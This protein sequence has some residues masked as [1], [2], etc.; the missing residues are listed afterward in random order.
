MNVPYY[1][2]LV[3]PQCMKIISERNISFEQFTIERE[4]PWMPGHTEKINISVYIRNKCVTIVGISHQIGDVDQSFRFKML[5]DGIIGIRTIVM[6]Y[7][8]FSP[9]K[10]YTFRRDTPERVLQPESSYSHF[11]VRGTDVIYSTSTGNLPKSI[12]DL[13]KSLCIASLSY[14]QCVAYRVAKGL[15]II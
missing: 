8:V 4:V 10:C 9:Y 15:K 3:R 7:D 2:E 14:N 1:L 11:D 13:H 5:G 12:D 6:R